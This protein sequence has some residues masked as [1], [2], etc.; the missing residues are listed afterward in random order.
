MIRLIGFVALGVLFVVSVGLLFRGSVVED[1]SVEKAS[2]RGIEAESLEMTEQQIERASDI[3]SERN[4]QPVADD[5]DQEP[6]EVDPSAG[7]LESAPQEPLRV[8]QTPDDARA[9]AQG[10]GADW[11]EIEAVSS[12]ESGAMENEILNFLSRR[13][14]LGI[15]SIAD[16]RCDAR[17]C[18][19]QLTGL[20]EVPVPMLMRELM[21][22]ESLALTDARFRFVDPT[23]G[24]DSIE[25]LISYDAKAASETQ[26]A[27]PRVSTI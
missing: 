21:A 20:D 26:T 16:V 11:P 5:A 24:F 12:P 4:A 18:K 7:G 22:E 17:N 15:T 27:G 6:S 13:S 3:A 9:R 19:F 25:L 14:D 8:G 23:L 1:S 10:L 2:V